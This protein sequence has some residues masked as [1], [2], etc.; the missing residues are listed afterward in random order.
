[1]DK[2]HTMIKITSRNEELFKD[3]LERCLNLGVVAATGQIPS[4]WDIEHADRMGMYWSRNED[5]YYIYGASNDFWAFIRAEG[6][7]TITLEFMARYKKDWGE[8]VEKLC[9]L[10]LDVELV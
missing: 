2:T 10:F 4:A 1:M 9:S 8:L 3:T 6:E 5:R 7:N